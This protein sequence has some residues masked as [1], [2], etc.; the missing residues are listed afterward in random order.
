MTH[1]F[2]LALVAQPFWRHY[3]ASPMPPP[4]PL[5][6]WGPDSPSPIF[7]VILW[8]R[9]RVAGGRYEPAHPFANSIMC[10]RSRLCTIQDFCSV[11]HFEVHAPVAW[12]L[13]ASVKAGSHQG[14][15][16]SLVPRA[17]QGAVS[18]A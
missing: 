1:H 15:Q 7:T 2:Y 18:Q 3:H 9:D 4:T 17:V 13:G 16:A 10:E 14:R 6:G 8:R 11:P 12:A 5:P